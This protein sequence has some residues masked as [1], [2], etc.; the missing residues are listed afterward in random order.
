[1]LRVIQF[2]V[3]VD[4]SKRDRDNDD[5]GLEKQLPWKMKFNS[6]NLG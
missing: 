4:V 1:V 2:W 5:D 6:K 3:V